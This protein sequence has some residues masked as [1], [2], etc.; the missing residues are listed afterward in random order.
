MRNGA[1]IA[2]AAAIAGCKQAQPPATT[3]AGGAGAPAGSGGSAT[4][5]SGSG[6]SGAAGPGSATAAAPKPAAGGKPL[7]EALAGSAGGKPVLLALDA[8]GQLI[9]RTVDG[10]QSSVLLPG[11]Y[12]DAVH[13]GALDLV[14]LRRDAGIDVVDLRAPGPAT[15]K[16]LVTAPPK[17]L[18]KLGDHFSEPPHWNPAEVVI[19]LGTPC[20]QA[21]GVTLSW[22]KGGAGTQSYSENVKAVAKEWFAAEEHRIRREQTP[23]F[24]QKIP[25][26]HKVPKAIGTCHVD[27]K[28]EL[29][30]DDCG[31]GLVF[32]A[33]GA[34]IVVVSANADKCPATQ[35]RLYDPATKKYAPVPGVAEDDPEARS[36][37]PFVFDASGTSYLVGD[38]VCSGRTCTS[39]GTQAIGWLEADRVLDAS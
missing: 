16:T 6:G 10:S 37:G 3:G 14:W 34:E 39:V 29:G 21:T 23:G 25:R 30:R 22:A 5:T 7:R 33:T 31:H 28:E 18:D 2:I 35:C 1:L 9:A 13:D 32:G 24:A 8:K 17:A 11:P 26:P 19:F 4:A 12:G 38:K 27:I 15:A 20:H 36:C